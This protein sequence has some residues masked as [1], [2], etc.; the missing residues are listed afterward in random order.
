MKKIKYIVVAALALTVTAF[1]VFTSPTTRNNA[2]A[3][4]VEP[5]TYSVYNQAEIVIPS[6]ITKTD[7]VYDVCDNTRYQFNI[8]G[9]TVVPEEGLY[10]AAV[11]SVAISAIS[12]YDSNDTLLDQI[13]F[14]LCALYSANN[15]RDMMSLSYSNGSTSLVLTKKVQPVNLKGLN[16]NVVTLNGGQKGYFAP[17][18]ITPKNN[19]QL[20]VSPGEPPL[21][22]SESYVSALYSANVVLINNTASS[23][24]IVFGNGLYDQSK[25]NAENI[26]YFD[27]A[28]SRKAMTYEIETPYTTTIKN[29]L[30]NVYS[31]GLM[32]SV[33]G[34]WTYTVTQPYNLNDDMVAPDTEIFFYG[35]AHDETDPIE[36]P[37]EEEDDPITITYKYNNNTY[38]RTFESGETL[39][40]PVLEVQPGEE[41]TGWRIEGTDTIVDNS[42]IVT[43]NLTLIANIR[44]KSVVVSFNYEGVSGQVVTYGHAVQEPDPP[45]KE[46]YTF[47]GW[48]R[49]DQLN[50]KFNFT[51]D[52]VTEN[53]TLYPGFI[54]TEQPTTSETP[55][56]EEGVNNLFESIGLTGL[57]FGVQIVIIIGAIIFIE[58]LF[59]RRR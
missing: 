44:V 12:S 1:A 42:T 2:Y 3:D 18:S 58:V 32:T 27:N 35:E 39:T 5:L 57:T 26:S 23:G 56:V 24:V 21:N 59:K 46:G 29:N 6:N 52:T 37:A 13:Q 55:A 8:Y 11:V 51:T 20:Y 7:V 25:T 38:T 33:G 22:Y 40:F 49:D 41:M 19:G 17:L 16:W 53:I 15:V 34:K 10:G 9:R 36:P 47:T 50:Q 43:E 30:S 28:L 31:A 4:G 48:Y 14:D 45:T 54:R